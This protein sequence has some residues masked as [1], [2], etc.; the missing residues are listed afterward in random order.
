MHISKSQQVLTI[1]VALVTIF[2]LFFGSG[3]PA[4]AA[5]NGAGKELWQHVPG[6]PPPAHPGAK[7]D[8][9]PGHFNGNRL[10]RGG[11]VSLLARAPHEHGKSNSDSTLIISLPDPNGDFQDFMIQE[12]PVMEE[13][14]AANHP[15][16]KTYRGAGVDNPA[17]TI[18][19]DLSPLGFHASVR[20]PHGAWYIDPYYHLDDSLYASYYGRDLLQSP[21]S[22]FVEGQLA[23]PELSLSRAFYHA[24]DTVDLL[25]LGFPADAAVTIQISDPDGN[26]A[27]RELT[28]VA[29]PDGTLSASFVADPDGNL[30]VH[31]L[32]AAA[33]DASAIA[34][35][36]VVSDEDNSVDPPVGDVLRTYRLALLSDPSYATFFGGSANVTA[37]KAVLMNRVDQVYEDETSIR[38][39][40][41]ANNDNVNLDTAAQ[42]TGANGPCGTAACFTAAQLS[43]CA[44]STLTRNRIVVGQLIGASN[45]D[46]GHVALGVN[47]GGVASLGVVGR[48]AKAQGCTGLPAPVGDFYAVDYVAHEM[49]HQFAGNHTFNGVNLNCAGGNRSAANSVE[50]GS[51]SSIMAYAGICTANDDLQPHSDPYWSQRSLQEISTYTASNQAAINEV[52]TASLREFDTNGDSFR[53]VYNG[54]QSAPV[55]RGTNYT[56]A[57]ILAALQGIPGWPAGVTVAVANFGGGGAPSDNGFQVTFNNGALAGTNVTDLSLT[58]FNGANGFVGETDKGGPVSNKGNTITPTGNNFPLV[59]AP[60]GFTIPLRTPFALTGSATDPDGDTLT[61]MWEQ[62][63]RG[64]ATGTALT[65][66]TKTN[67]PLFR[68]FGT[69]LQTAIYVPSQYNSPGENMVTTDPT[70]VFP[71]MAQIVANNTN[72]ETGTCPAGNIDCFSEFLPTASYVGF[73]ANAS[74]LSLHFRLTVR[75]GQGGVN[76]NGTSETLLLLATNAGPFLVTSPNT[77]VTYTGGSTQTVTWNPANTNLAPVNAANVKI[78]LSADGGFTYP[79][80]LSASTPNDGTENVT[81][82]NVATTRARLKVEGAGNIFFD[83]SNADFTLKAV[84]VLTNSLGGGSQ[85]VQYSDS[86]SPDLTIK[87][88]DGDSLG[89]DLSASASGLPAGMSLSIVSTT[90]DATLPGVRIWKVDGATTAA[91][92]SYPVTVTVNDE[93]GGTA[94]TSFTIQVTREDATATYTGDMLAFTPS[95]GSAANVLLRATVQDSSVVTGSGDTQPGDVRNATVTF[96]EAGTTLCGPLPVALINGATTVGSVNCTVSLGLGSHQ[97]DIQVN[98]YYTG[99]ASAIVEV[100]APDG[101]FVTGGGFLTITN[102]SG[103][104]PA[105]PG[106]LMNFGFNVKHKNLKNLQGQ[107]NIIFRANGHTYQIKSTAI[108]SLGITFKKATG[109]GT[110]SGQVST[111]CY[112]LA[113]F[114]SKANLTDITDPLAPVSLG[115]NLTLQITMTDKG[116]PG[117]SDTIGVTLWN[118][119][120]LVFSSQWKGSS[121]NEQ[122][123]GGGNL[124]I[125]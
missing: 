110:C 75:D 22:T 124:V 79:Y 102:S 123:L 16:I 116:D 95:G 13:A 67:G 54:Q 47:G 77:A 52:Q 120:K 108:D 41:V 65:S 11:M 6:T 122:I 105:A 40:L 55:V 64:A 104:T 99:T 90:D 71:D 42:A 106:S 107:V 82:P 86:L 93:S 51:G 7:P 72:A 57:G 103:T 29:N 117:S 19:L 97:I 85:S 62:N 118:G 69:A 109:G 115:G 5:G 53:L 48:S 88:S 78:S 30:G 35:Y 73:G 24:G 94:T 3:T 21:N 61:Y 125:H 112:G 26:F 32:T 89:K 23:E 8:I 39:V 38:L 18:R 1:V 20:S 87:A 80:V 58:D 84:P 50:P 34:S 74:P 121:T 113:D 100:T 4:S 31:D 59:T 28:A 36:Q 92:G 56:A 17:D 81:L 9:A 15:E 60:A 111:T 119:N 49:G 25:G 101:S 96:S 43:N 33:G 37:A 27:T 70:R 10:N 83:I 14:L 46:I 66:N 44:S 98:N 68:Q 12:S 91:P 2:S 63:D 76:S 45:Y 114:R